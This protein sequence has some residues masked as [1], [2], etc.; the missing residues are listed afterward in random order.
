MIETRAI[1][2]EEKMELLSVDLKQ[3]QLIAEEADRK[4][5]EVCTQRTHALG[6]HTY[7]QNT[8]PD[9]FDQHYHHKMK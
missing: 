1:K 4:Y 9:K 5:E 6:L 7:G 8:N 2:D 3:A